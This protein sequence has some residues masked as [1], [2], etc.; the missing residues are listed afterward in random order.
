M[1][2][3]A[4][5]PNGNVFWEMCAQW[6]AYKFYPRMQFNDNEWLWNTLNNLHKNPFCEEFRYNNFFIQDY[7]VQRH[8]W[9]F[10]GR[11]WNESQNPEDPFQAYMRMTMSG[12]TKQKLSQLG[13]E[14]WEYGARM[15]TFDFDHLRDLGA[16]TIGVRNQTAMTQQ[17]DK[18]WLV[19][20]SDCPENYGH[21]A[22]KLNVPTNEKLLVAEFAGLADTTGYRGYN[23]RYAG[24]KVGFVALKN[25][26]TRIYGDVVTATRENP[27]AQVEFLC[28]AGCKYVWLV[29]SGAPTSYW[30]RGWDGS[31]ANDEQW[32]YKVRFYNTNLLGNGN[33]AL[34]TAIG[35][36]AGDAVPV[37]QGVYNLQGQF[38]GRSTTGLP[39]GIYVVGGRKVVVP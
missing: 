7:M 35:E 38:V 5:S 39:A 29:V 34:P 2:T 31:T 13:D 22:I 23:T 3:W 17:K 30:C 32:P 28:P 37:Q 8:G 33:T 4:D 19:N 16:A 26:G 6:Q 36:V 12:T 14:M 1:Y 20:E 21:N 15:A 10:I 18:Y 24:W 27:N 9:D 25:D 11:L